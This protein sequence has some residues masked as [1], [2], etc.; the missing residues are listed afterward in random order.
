MSR[1]R[2]ATSGWVHDDWAGRF[3]AGV[4]VPAGS[5][6]ADCFRP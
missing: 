5:P 6:T 2:V 4:P 3:Y 1:V